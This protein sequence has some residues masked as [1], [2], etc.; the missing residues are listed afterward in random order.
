M[1]KIWHYPTY[2][3]EGSKEKLAHLCDIVALQQQRK[4]K[5]KDTL[6]VKTTRNDRKKRNMHLYIVRMFLHLNCQ[7]KCNRVLKN[8][9]KDDFQFAL[10]T[11]VPSETN[12]ALTL[13]QPYSVLI[14]RRSLIY[15]VSIKFL[16][17]NYQSLCNI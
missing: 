8:T 6:P 3:P 13:W 9:S 15:L 1:R 5:R 12:A 10:A 17:F 14:Q 2:W 16:Q 11:I 4:Q 7:I